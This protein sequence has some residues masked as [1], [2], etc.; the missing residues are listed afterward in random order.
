ML[1]MWYAQAETYMDAISNTCLAR[2]SL[3][4]L[5]SLANVWHLWIER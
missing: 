2:Y 4:S 5:V 3:E 1:H